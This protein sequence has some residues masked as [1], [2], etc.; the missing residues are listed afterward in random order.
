MGPQPTSAMCLVCLQPT[1]AM[2]AARGVHVR[3]LLL[4]SC[5]RM[6]REGPQGTPAPDVRRKYAKSCR[7]CRYW[8]ELGIKKIENLA[9]TANVNIQDLL[10]AQSRYWSAR[11]DVANRTALALA[12]AE[13]E[14]MR[15]VLG[16][17]SPHP[18]DV[19]PRSL[20]KPLIDFVKK[21]LTVDAILDFHRRFLEIAPNVSLSPPRVTI[22]EDKKEDA[23]DVV[24]VS[25]GMPP[26]VAVQPSSQHHQLQQQ[27]QQQ[28]PPRA[29]P[30][31]QLFV[32]GT[33]ANSNNTTQSVVQVAVTS[34]PQQEWTQQRH[35][36]Q[37]GYV[38]PAAS[39]YSTAAT[40][41]PPLALVPAAGSLAPDGR[42]LPL[43]PAQSPPRVTFDDDDHPVDAKPT[44]DPIADLAPRDPAFFI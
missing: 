8:L 43:P 4:C 21:N 31:A 26:V 12:Q 44:I 18:E 3:A 23:D 20:R 38:S 13:A 19:R 27:Q 34:S 33:A 32:A 36:H 37:S 35:H 22:D 5:V 30:P 7:A 16:L 40:V 2:S 14:A 10:A 11:A 9:K 39:N 29:L 25:N 28:P 17:Y 1:P 15:P 24:V 41:V 6:L 42:A